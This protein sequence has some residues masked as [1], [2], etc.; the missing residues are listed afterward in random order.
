MELLPVTLPLGCQQPTQRYEW[1]C[2]KY[3]V[4]FFLLK[5]Y[6]YGILA[7]ILNVGIKILTFRSKK[8]NSDA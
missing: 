5:L 3:G 6:G 1:M 8:I 2:Q 7:K 4:C